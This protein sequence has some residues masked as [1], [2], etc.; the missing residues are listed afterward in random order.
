M[1]FFKQS[2][3]L[4]SS[5][6]VFSRET[7]KMVFFKRALPVRHV[8]GRT[9][10]ILYMSMGDKYDFKQF[11]LNNPTLSNEEV[12]MLK[13]KCTM[14]LLTSEEINKI[15]NSII[16]ND[17]NFRTTDDNLF[18]ENDAEDKIKKSYKLE[19]YCRSLTTQYIHRQ[20]QL[21]AENNGLSYN[22]CTTRQYNKYLEDLKQF[23]TT[24]KTFIDENI[25]KIDKTISYQNLELD[26][27]ELLNKQPI[28]I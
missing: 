5:I 14:K 3:Y 20:I 9:E 16:F 7:A 23:Y 10:G 12:K 26:L 18:T 11:D 25:T 19:H 2:Q 4:N 22:Y 1:E 15:N 24:N 13:T 8:Y 27:N 6:F 17:V 28:P 21:E